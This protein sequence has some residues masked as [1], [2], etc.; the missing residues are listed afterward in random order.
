ML[1]RFQRRADR[2]WTWTSPVTGYAR[3]G[4]GLDSIRSV[5]AGSD[6]EEP[7][8]NVAALGAR[9]VVQLVLRTMAT[10]FVA[11][12]GTVALARLLSPSEFGA[13]AVVT[14]FV[15]LFSLVGD[16]GIGPALVQQAHE[17]SQRE[18]STAFVTQLAIWTAMFVAV[19]ILAGWVPILRPDL[20]PETPGLARLLGAGFVLNGLRSIPTL[21]LT[22]VLRFGPLA[23]IEVIQ[24]VVYFGVAVALAAAAF[25]VWSFAIAAIVQGVVGTIAVYAV[26]RHWPGLTFDVQIARRLW[27]FGLG[28]QA[29]WIATWAREAVVPVFGSLAG[30]LAAVGILGFA[31]RNGQLVSAVEQI[32]ARIAFPAFSRLR[33]D[34]ERGRRTAVEALELSLLAVWV[35]QAWIVA[36]ADVVIPTIFSSAWAGAIVP[37]QLVCIGSL[38]GAPTY[39]LRSYVYAAGESRRAFLLSGASLV[40]LV[41]TFPVLALQLGLTGAAASFVI[42]S[43]VGLL[44]FI[45]ATQA[46]VPF[47]WAA[48]GRIGLATVLAGASAAVIVR[49]VD[50]LPGIVASGI[51]YLV[52]AGAGL[53]VLTPHL[54]RRAMAFARGTGAA[55]QPRKAHV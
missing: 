23:A 32:I 4:R 17:P 31:W 44:L 6:P 47:P 51:I 29:G 26:W 35:I 15:T 20:P 14:L 45:R 40:L 7:E 8:L 52:V 46:A 25:G 50:G 27:R 53:R 28:F 34:P 19:W 21:M 39:V 22:R 54:T 16:F 37:L 30:G 48:L 42:S 9:A 2:D 5:M 24:Q 11:L 12:V 36:T 13:F 41:V 33:M 49:R 55:R 43:A 10:R 18:I 1:R 38:A 3:A